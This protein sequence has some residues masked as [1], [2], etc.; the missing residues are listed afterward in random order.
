MR[1]RVLVL[2][3]MTLLLTA[4]MIFNIPAAGET[5]SSVAVSGTV[6]FINDIPLKDLT[7]QLV[8]SSGSVV[9]SKKTSAK[10]EFGFFVEAEHLRIVIDHPAYKRYSEDLG[11]VNTSV[12][13]K[14]R[15]EPTEEDLLIKCLV[16]RKYVTLVEGMFD[17]NVDTNFLITFPFDIDEGTLDIYLQADSEINE[18]NPQGFLNGS[19]AYYQN[20]R[21]LHFNPNRNLRGDRNMDY[22]HYE[23]FIGA[24]LRT[25]EGNPVFNKDFN[26]TFIPEEIDTDGDGMPDTADA[27]PDDPTEVHDT[28]QDKVGDNTDAFPNDWTQW[29]DRD[30]DGYGDNATGKFPDRFVDDPNEWNDTDDDGIGDNADEDDDNDGFPDEVEIYYRSNPRNPASTPADLDKDMIPDHE[31]EDIDGDGVSNKK[32]EEAGTDPYDPNDKPP[33][34]S[35]TVVIIVLIVIVLILIAIVSFGWYSYRNRSVE[36]PE[37]EPTRGRSRGRPDRR[38]DSRRR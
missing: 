22:P 19:K 18:M 14:I 16:D 15:L 32:E 33:V 6:K 11:F 13:K 10:G 8:N 30:G 27:F 26:I 25:K 35:P 36:E 7:V 23:M 21:T 37:P 3:V 34:V 2:M 31:D 38:N 29:S 1:K 24:G 9:D 20:N 28:D 12:N 5:R 4:G 17:V